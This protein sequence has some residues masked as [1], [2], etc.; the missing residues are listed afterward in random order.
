[1]H[2]LVR[3][4][5]NGLASGLEIFL[6]LSYLTMII[7]AKLLLP[8]VPCTKAKASRH[9][10]SLGDVEHRLCFYVGH[11]V[12]F[13]KCPMLLLRAQMP[14]RQKCEARYCG[15][16]VILGPRLVKEDIRCQESAV[17]QAGSAT[18]QLCAKFQPTAYLVVLVCVC[19]LTCV[20]MTSEENFRSPRRSP[21]PFR[22]RP[23]PVRCFRFRYPTHVILASSLCG[24][25]AADQLVSRNSDANRGYTQ[26]R[27][28]TCR[29]PIV[30][31]SAA[32]AEKRE[33]RS[34]CGWMVAKD[35]PTGASR[36]SA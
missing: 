13:A 30:P 20:G 35:R 23:R 28:A 17:L 21:Q 36:R 16:L 8:D 32:C 31:S 25:L 5:E 9:A 34:G 1:M 12:R 18:I 24:A 29:F 26:F 22:H 10:I 33:A 3:E 14:S 2:G 11:F 7:P 19:P 27:L 4:S 15:A 6:S